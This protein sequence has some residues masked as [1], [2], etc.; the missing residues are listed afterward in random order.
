MF[1]LSSPFPNVGAIQC[2]RTKRASQWETP[3]DALPLFWRFVVIIKGERSS[4]DTLSESLRNHHPFSPLNRHHRTNVSG[5]IINIPCAVPDWEYCYPQQRL[6]GGWPTVYR[7]K[8][9]WVI[10]EG[11]RKQVRGLMMVQKYA[12]VHLPWSTWIV[13]GNTGVVLL[14]QRA[15]LRPRMVFVHMIRREVLKV[16]KINHDIFMPSS[17]LLYFDRQVCCCRRNKRRIKID[18]IA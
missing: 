1:L 2:V 16:W 7:G 3:G 4:Q 11:R 6:G 5:I 18:D 10:E 17:F 12:L 9:V 13:V 14:F 15:V 8:K